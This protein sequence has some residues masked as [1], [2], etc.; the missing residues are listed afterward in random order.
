MAQKL[1][2]FLGS[3]ALPPGRTS[4]AYFIRVT[5]ANRFHLLGGTIR[6]ITV[7]METGFRKCQ[8][9]ENTFLAFCI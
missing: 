4:L 8:W 2:L 6:G 7:S 9:T 5:E 3:K 1:L